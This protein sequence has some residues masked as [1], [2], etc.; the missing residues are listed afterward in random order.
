MNKKTALDI[1]YSEDSIGKKILKL[2]QKIEN[3]YEF[4]DDEFDCVLFVLDSLICKGSVIPNNYNDLTYISPKF[5]TAQ[6]LKLSEVIKSEA[7][8]LDTIF[9]RNI[10][11]EEYKKNLFKIKTPSLRANLIYLKTEVEEQEELFEMILGKPLGTLQ[12]KEA[13]KERITI[14]YLPSA[15]ALP[16]FYENIFELNKYV[17]V[18]FTTIHGGIPYNRKKA[19]A[20]LKKGSFEKLKMYFPN[21]EFPL[22][23]KEE[24]SDMDSYVLDKNPRLKQ[25]LDNRIYKLTEASGK[26]V[27][28]DALQEVLFLQETEFFKLVDDKESICF[29]SIVDLVDRRLARDLMLPFK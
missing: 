18:N 14:S 28:I 4:T 17:P 6:C 13:N 19:N 29:D 2:K 21:E 15:T 24:F 1:V 8:L 26:F 12:Q 23:E 11:F 10:T 9:F 27:S 25:F 20:N 22:F 16:N 3:I 5:S 7:L